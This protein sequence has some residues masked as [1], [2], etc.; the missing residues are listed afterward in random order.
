MNGVLSGGICVALWLYSMYIGRH[1]MHTTKPL[2]V[3]D[4]HIYCL[5]AVLQQSD[6]VTDRLR[7]ENDILK[8]QVCS[9]I[10]ILSY[11][12][13]FCMIKQAL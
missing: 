11:W 10:L 4:A 6:S 2:S 13:D 12:F 1:I 3:C 5:Q 9:Q 8:A 7:E